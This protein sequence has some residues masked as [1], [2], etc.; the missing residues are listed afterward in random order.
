ME[1]PVKRLIPLAAV[2]TLLVAAPGA[3]AAVDLDG[4]STRLTLNSGTAAA[5][6]ELGVTVRPTGPARARG[7][8][9]TFPI[10]TGTIDPATAAGTIQH[11][12]GLRLS[13]GGNAITLRDYAVRVGRRI[14][15]TA[16]VGGARVAILALTGRP[17]VRRD[18]FGTVVSGLTARLT[19][20]AARALNQ[21]FGVHAFSRGLP[22]GGI[23]V[24]A[25]PSQA[26]WQS[27]GATAL[28][29]DAGTVAALTGL[30]VTPGVIEPAT[31]AGTSASFPITGGIADLDLSGGD[32][33]HAGG[34]SLSAGATVVR[35]EAFDIRLGATPQLF[36]SVNGGAEKIAVADLD[37]SA[38]T[39]AVAGRQVTVG[40]VG[41]RLT[42][43]AADALNAAFGTT[44]L[45]AGL[46]LGVATVQASAR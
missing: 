31:I 42:Q 15:L 14:T 5:L 6:G 28:A 30:G 3:P 12:G 21:T 25:E 11:R 29:L 13:G 34:I 2:T 41:V 36:A 43:G 22:L 24:S 40:N 17:R 8:R 7:A 19:Q 27:T 9:V 46:A 20:A 16:R 44:A 33:T 35:L 32:V 37:V 39:P 18:G 38:A 26:E 4:G 10:S 1:E 45:T 23:R